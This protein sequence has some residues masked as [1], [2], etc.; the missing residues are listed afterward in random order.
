MSSLKILERR[1]SS[2]AFPLSSVV[3]SRFSSGGV[4]GGWGGV[5]LEAPYYAEID[6]EEQGVS[7]A[8]YPHVHT[9]WGSELNIQHTSGHIKHDIYVIPHHIRHNI[10]FTR[11][12]WPITLPCCWRALN[13]VVTC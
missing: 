8:Q 11:C 13:N 6:A 2:I 10:A 7:S 3:R 12:G 9:S 4:G 1:L 5:R